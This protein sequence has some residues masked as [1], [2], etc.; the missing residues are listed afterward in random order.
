MNYQINVVLNLVPANLPSDIVAADENI[1][2]FLA[3][4]EYFEGRS[5]ANYLMGDPNIISRKLDQGSEKSG[6]W[7]KSLV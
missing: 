6:S 1:C 2:D 4:N 5:F 7:R 3:P